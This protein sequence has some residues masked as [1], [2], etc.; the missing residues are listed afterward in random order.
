MR[1]TTKDE[2]REIL[3]QQGKPCENHLEG[4]LS[5]F[6]QMINERIGKFPAKRDKVK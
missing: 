2:A 3:D 1:P 6:T 5:E 4:I